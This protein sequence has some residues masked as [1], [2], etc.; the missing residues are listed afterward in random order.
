M[1]QSILACE[2]L[3]WCCKCNTASSLHIYCAPHQSSHFP[4]LLGIAHVLQP[5]IER[6][7]FFPPGPGLVPPR[8]PDLYHLDGYISA[9]TCTT[10]ELTLVTPQ[11]PDFCHFVGQTCV[12][13]VPRLEPPWCP[14]PHGSLLI[15][16]G[17]PPVPLSGLPGSAVR[18][19]EAAGLSCPRP[20]SWDPKVEQP[21]L[22]NLGYMNEMQRDS[23]SPIVGPRS[24]PAQTWDDK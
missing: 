18:S 8:Y 22:G 24:R 9:Q 21:S 20:E 14:C 19:R 6:S 16:G 2:F 3:R 1:T 12:T 11:C 5:L 7:G 10:L 4:N 17:M 15:G 13:K 23:R